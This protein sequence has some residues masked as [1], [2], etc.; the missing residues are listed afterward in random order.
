MTKLFKN[1]KFR[2]LSGLFIFLFIVFYGFGYFVINSLKQ[3]YNQSIESS[4]IPAVKDLRHEFHTYFKD[5]YVFE[6]IKHEFDINLLYAQI[7]LV[8]NNKTTLLLKSNDLKEFVLSYNNIQIG[9]LSTTHIV[10]STQNIPKLTPKKIKVATIILEKIE[11][12]VVVMQCAIPFQEKIPFL[13]NMKIFLW[14]SLIILL[15]VILIAVYFV[16]SHSLAQTKNVVDVVKNIKIDGEPH[17]IEPTNISKEIDE[18][19]ETF[20]TLVDNLQS[21]YKKVKDFGQNASH[22]LKTPLTIIR[23]EIEVG[24]RKERSN[25]EYKTILKSTMQEL[26]YLQEVIEKILFLSSNTNSDI[27]KTFEEVYIDEVVSDVIEEKK[28]F[29]KTKNITLVLQILEPTTKMGN[30]GLLKIVCHNL[31]D[32]GIKYSYENSHIDIFLQ[33]DKLIIEDFGCGIPKNELS[34]IFDRFYRVDKVRNHKSG[35]GLGLSIVKTILELHNFS[36]HI[37]SVEEHSTKV[38]ISF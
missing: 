33:H 26:I 15:F 13:E 36:I 6:E 29:A 9:N 34:K 27:T 10:F 22:E 20:N 37:E 2:L 14:I 38:T 21:S 7:I 5:A 25:E 31:L 16:L 24:L 3:N 11:D 18:L 8:E 35:T 23:G 32:N 17:P 1:I 28:A 4:L 12:K 19:I 30:L